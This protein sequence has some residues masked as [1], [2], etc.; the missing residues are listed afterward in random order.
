MWSGT[1]AK[2][3]RTVA[4]HHCTL[5]C[6]A[7]QRLL[8]SLLRP[9]CPGIHSNATASLPS[10]VQNLLDHDPSLTPE[11]ILQQLAEQYLTGKPC[12]PPVSLSPI[13]ITLF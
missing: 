13:C 1:A 10:P 7:D 9:T 6:S 3:G 5:L 8:S 12:H 11:G 4:Y 2:L